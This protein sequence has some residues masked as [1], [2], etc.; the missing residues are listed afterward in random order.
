M[1]YENIQ[2]QNPNFCK[3]PQLGTL[4]TID[5]TNPTTVLRMK[6]TGG[7]TILDLT[8]SSNILDDDVRLEYVGPPNLNGMVDDLTFFTFERINDTK[9]LIRRWQTRMAYRELLLKEQVVK[10]NI[11]DVSYNA[12]DFAVEYYNRTFIK[13]NEYDNFL[14]MSD[15][16]HIKT[17]TRLFLGPS[18]DTSNLG[19]TEM[20]VVT[21][22][23]DIHGEKRVYLSDH[24][25]YEYSIGDFITVYTHVYIYSKEGSPGD[26]RIGSIIKHDA[27]TWNIVERDGKNLYKRVT[28]SKWCP[29]VRGIA[30]VVNTNMLFVRPYDS[31]LNWRSMFMSNVKSDKNTVFEV[32]DVFFDNQVVYKLQDTVTY[33]EDDGD[34]D[35]ELWE[36]Y[37]YQE[38]TL[39][40]YS[41]NI[42]LW[43]EEQIKFAFHK[44]ITINA[45]VRDQF[46]VGLRDVT[47]QFYIEPGGDDDAYLWPY[48][49][50][51]E[52]D[53]N[54]KCTMDYRTGH[55]YLGSTLVTAR[56]TG[57]ANS[58][59]S[60]FC[61]AK[62][63]INLISLPYYP[64]VYYTIYQFKYWGGHA[65]S[66]QIDTPFMVW[67]LPEGSFNR[68]KVLPYHF[69]KMRS[70]F[71]TP[72]GDWGR[73][74][75]NDHFESALNVAIFLPELYR[76]TESDGPSLAHRGYGFSNW[77]VN[78]IHGFFF[79]GNQ[80]K[81]VNDF[82][83]DGNMEA[84][85]NF[86]IHHGVA[87]ADP[88]A[89]GGRT[90]R[91]EGWPPYLFVVQ[92]DES[93]RVQ[94]SQL[95]L[96]LHTH[97]LDG[98]PFDELIG[99]V[100]LD[101]FIFVEDAI[102]KFW[103]EKNPIDTDIWIR[104]RPFAFSLDN[105]TL[106]MW[107][108]VV[109]WK[110]DNGY[111]EITDQI[112]LD[113]FDAG[114][115]L[116]G[117]EVLYDPPEDL[118]YGALVFIKIEVYDEAYIS[119]FVLVEYWFYITPDY[120][121]PYLT[122]LSPSREAENI[123]V[124][125][126]IYFEIWDVGSGVD[127]DTLEVLVNSRLVGSDDLTIDST[128]I[129]RIKITY[130]PPWN[131][132]YSKDY[133]ITVKV[134]DVSPQ[135]NKMNSAYTFYTVDSTGIYIT[136]PS[137]TPCKRGMERFEDVSAILLADGNGID[138]RTIRMQVYNKDVDPKI[139]P[140]VYRIG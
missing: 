45:Q 4:C 117:I 124:D 13:G 1:A 34:L 129:K 76:G 11:G 111:R 84:Y 36:Y 35:T 103:S 19:A 140:I 115:G 132:Y 100:T 65:Y 20:V 69:I 24:A 51:A 128:N 126:S 85:T 135:E 16:Q 38:D 123:P 113:N 108:R 107:I 96:S 82:E 98:W 138:K 118:P 92:P 134:S 137:P 47:V 63:G 53:I 9:C 17:G 109:S 18:S 131:L 41:S 119:N 42:N 33:K 81:L 101:Q 40:P 66:R 75:P 27:L 102:P 130:K 26:D 8:L 77:P 46:H 28:A 31:Y 90:P 91:R 139:T 87:S 39:S 83:S 74:F 12:I 114:G 6:D 122:N 57:S 60:E 56:A 50:L 64:D 10:Q 79:W 22:I 80:I 127:L 120:K 2:I 21:H 14:Y 3:G 55:D 99:H 58:T 116:L 48:S 44:T 43:T 7:N 112:D 72:G 70:C 29:A 110:G 104:L 97:W 49:G 133:K 25:N 67:W 68:A 95:N 86:K 89:P 37:N 52:T 106:R 93:D 121:A 15:T 62:P 23:A 54:G 30:S 78:P 94:L 88:E 73:D 59:G 32:Y 61:W 105:D 71:S 5:T 125:S 136:D